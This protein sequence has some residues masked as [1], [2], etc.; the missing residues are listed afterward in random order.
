MVVYWHVPASEIYNHITGLLDNNESN[1]VVYY[2]TL[3]VSFGSWFPWTFVCF[4][5]PVCILELCVLLF[6]YQVTHSS[7]LAIAFA[8]SNVRLGPSLMLFFI[9]FVD[10]SPNTNVFLVNF[11]LL[12]EGKSQSFIP[13]RTC[14]VY[15]SILLLPCELDT[16]QIWPLNHCTVS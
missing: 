10:L 7:W 5:D 3:P 1:S 11:G 6:I 14:V 8:F 16:D 13:A 9:N 15:S 4:F 2:F 12:H